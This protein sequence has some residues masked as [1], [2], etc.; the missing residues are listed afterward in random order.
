MPKLYIATLLVLVQQRDYPSTD[1]VA[2]R[3]RSGQLI[4]TS[5]FHAIL[6]AQ[7]KI[8]FLINQLLCHNYT[9]CEITELHSWFMWNIT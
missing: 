3:H 2:K 1:L 4:V 7:N 5:M 8:L 6:T 9:V